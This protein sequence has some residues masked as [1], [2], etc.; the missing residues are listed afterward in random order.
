MVTSG[1]LYTN[2]MDKLQ[3]EPGIDE[4][5]ITVAIKDN[6]IV[7]L[8]GKVRSYAEKYTA[9]KAAE[10]VAK[11]KGVA[12]EIEVELIPSHKRGDADIANAALNALQWNVFVPHEQIKVAVENGHVTLT[13]KVEYNYQK[14]CAKDAVQDL[15]GV[16]YVTNDVTVKPS[17]VVSSSEVKRKIIK[18][19]ERNARIDASNIKV[20][21]D[22]SKVILKGKVRNFDE[23]REARTAA[24]SIPGVVNVVDYLIIGW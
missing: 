20:E 23:D 11:V 4:S 9:E 24:W 8:G 14:E 15:Y 1:E 2:V 13:G 18:E 7:I 19:F 3:F 12:N 16:T 5:N 21:V 6:G 10:T 17:A 22:G